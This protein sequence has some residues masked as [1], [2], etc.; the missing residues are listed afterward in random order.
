MK[1]REIL[2]DMGYNES[3]VFENPDYDSAIVGIS[4]GGRVIYDHDLMIAHL[5]DVDDMT[6]MDALILLII[7]Q[8]DQFHMQE[9]TLL[10]LCIKFKE[11]D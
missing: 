9:S 8:L 3:I 11:V 1:N 7:I 10:S 5:M 6:E 2:C 4:D